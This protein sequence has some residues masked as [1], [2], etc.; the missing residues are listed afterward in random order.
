MTESGTILLFSRASCESSGS[1]KASGSLKYD[2]I[3]A[4]EK[5]IFLSHALAKGA[6]V[7]SRYVLKL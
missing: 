7:M 6:S 3:P 1:A 2:M 4:E 5:S